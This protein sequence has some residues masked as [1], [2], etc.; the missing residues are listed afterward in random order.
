MDDEEIKKQ[1]A[2]GFSESLEKPAK[3][4]RIKEIL[5]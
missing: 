2:C 4:Y 3:P 1:K 5:K